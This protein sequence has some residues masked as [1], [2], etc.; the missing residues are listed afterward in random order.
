MINHKLSLRV[1]DHQVGGLY[2]L[3]RIID[4]PLLSSVDI[5]EYPTSTKPLLI[6]KPRGRFYLAQISCSLSNNTYFF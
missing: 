1:P 4:Y 3:I 5:P 6:C 2:I